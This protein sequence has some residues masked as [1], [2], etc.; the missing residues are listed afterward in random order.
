MKSYYI[1]GAIGDIIY[2]LPAIKALGGGVIYNGLS[3]NQHAALAPLLECQSYVKGFFHESEFGLPKGF[4]NLEDFVHLQ[5]NPNH[6]IE[7]FAKV[8]GVKVDIKEPWLVLPGKSERRE[9]KVPY[10]VIN[11]T[12]RYRDKIFSYRRHLEMLRRN[13]CWPIVFLGLYEEYQIFRK[14]YPNAYIRW[15]KT[16]NLLEAAYIIQGAKYFTGTQSS[17]LAIAEGLG[18]SYFFERSPF[19]DNCR[20]GR[21][22]E[23]VLNNHTH[24]IHHALSRLQEIGRNLVK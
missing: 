16:D 8:M 9:E 21:T 11:I 10:A 1:R 2:S 3:F 22:N 7:S 13:T 24:K 12:P 4:V 18:R 19:L 5:K 15:V 23:T 17:L 14:K 20:T 6:I